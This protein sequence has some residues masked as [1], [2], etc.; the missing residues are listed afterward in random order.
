MKLHV[1]AAD[2]IASVTFEHG[3]ALSRCHHAQPSILLLETGTYILRCIWV[4]GCPNDQSSALMFF[5]D[6][7]SGSSR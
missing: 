4:C 2:T 6:I 5:V 3:K 1:C 7:I